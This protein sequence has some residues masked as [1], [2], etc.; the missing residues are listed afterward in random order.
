M[1]WMFIV[2]IEAAIPVGGVVFGA[3]LTICNNHG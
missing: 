3:P 1:W 2:F